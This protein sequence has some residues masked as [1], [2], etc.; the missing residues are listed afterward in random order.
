MAE[1]L[2]PMRWPCPGAGADGEWALVTQSGDA[3]RVLIVP[4][5]FDEM[6]RARAMLAAVMRHLATAGVAAVLPDLPGCGESV[7][8]FAAQSLNAWRAAMIAAARHFAASHVLALRGGALVAPP[9]L[10]GWALA[11]V[12]GDAVLRPLLRAASLAARARNEDASPAAL[13][14]QGRTQGLVLAGYPCGAALIAG[15]HGALPAGEGQQAIAL[16][17]LG[18][19]GPAPWVRQEPAP[20]PALAQALAARI[21]ADL[22][23]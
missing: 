8:D 14:E 4:P 17:D 11:P 22:A 5:L 18:A 23:A 19:A 2:A 16:S 3:A 20:A 10:P 13:L 9:T 12:S 6:N 21:V 7:Q 15:L 1:A